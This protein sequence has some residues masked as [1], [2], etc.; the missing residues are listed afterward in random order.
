MTDELIKQHGEDI[1][2]I[3]RDHGARTIR[4]FGSRATGAASTSSDLDLLIALDPDRDLLDLVAI[5]QDL[6]ALLMCSVDV[7]EE[8]GLSPYLRD[9]IL[10]EARPL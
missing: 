8:D 2:R 5:K 9:Q 4:M 3:A 6:E 1:K 10:R 7:V